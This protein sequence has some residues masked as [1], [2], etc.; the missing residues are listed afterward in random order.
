MKIPKPKLVNQIGI[1]ALP[2]PMEIKFEIEHNIIFLVVDDP[3]FNIIGY[4]KT[5]E[6][7]FESLEEDLEDAIKLYVHLT[8]PE[9]LEENA[10][11]FR[12]RLI[13]LEK[14]NNLNN[15][16]S[17]YTTSHVTTTYTFTNKT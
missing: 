9:D 8:K 4:G 13:E 14:I 1:Y 15:S 7:A 5:V 12:E 6:E 11:K 16:S 3:T 17:V 2:E 10:L